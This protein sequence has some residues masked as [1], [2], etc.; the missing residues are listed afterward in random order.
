LFDLFRHKRH[1]ASDLP[2][3]KPTVA[4]AVDSGSALTLHLESY[5]PDYRRFDLDEVIDCHEEVPELEALR[6]WAMTLHNQYPRRRSAARSL[7]RVM[8][9]TLP[10]RP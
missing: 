4:E 7:Y 1:H 5:D 6:R 10:I 3:I 8:P 2:A 9:P